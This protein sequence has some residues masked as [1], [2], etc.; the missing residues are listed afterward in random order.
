MLPEVRYLPSPIGEV[1]GTDVVLESDWE[2]AAGERCT[3]CGKEAFRLFNHSTGRVCKPCSLW[4]LDNYI[5]DGENV[6]AKILPDG[7]II[8]IREQAKGS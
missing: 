8:V 4:L 1:G 6:R 3:R 7:E 2:K 5:V